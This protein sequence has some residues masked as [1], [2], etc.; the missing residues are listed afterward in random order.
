MARIRV[1]TVIAA[2]PAQVWDEVRHVDRHTDWMA[3]AAEIRFHGD[4]REGRGTSFDCLTRVGPIR[5]KDRMTITAW[6]PGR[7][8]GV[9]HEGLVTGAGTFT[10]AGLRRGRTRFTWEE[11][12]TFPWWLG[13]P[14]GGA[15]GGVVLR[16]IWK[17]NLRV[18]KALVESHRA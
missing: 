12:L 8:I 11:Q 15:V 5:L 2:T 3:D 13:G 7:A 10:L 17:R 9:E 6:R 18:L 1:S 16:R 14:V 4:Q